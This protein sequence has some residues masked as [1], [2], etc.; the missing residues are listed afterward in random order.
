MISFV[1]GLIPN[2]WWRPILIGA[3][4]VILF[5]AW[6]A[7]Q[8]HD[9]A[10]EVKSNLTIQDQEGAIDVHNTAADALRDADSFDDVDEL[11]RSTD[12]LRDDTSGSDNSE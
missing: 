5:I 11:L 6:T 4:A 3:G 10:E 2:S 1:T 7:Y 12:G 8:R 9:A